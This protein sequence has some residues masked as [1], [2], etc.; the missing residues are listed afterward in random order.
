MV[1]DVR[2]QFDRRQLRAAKRIIG[3]MPVRLAR[4]KGRAIRRT[5]TALRTRV[6][7]AI[8]EDLP[9]KQSDLFKRGSKRRPVIE[10]LKRG[11][12]M[13]RGSPQIIE[14]RIEVTGER[15]PL[16]RFTPRQLKGR[17]VSYKVRK[18][19]GRT[20]IEDGAF[21]VRFSS[22]D[23]LTGET[24][25]RVAVVK[26]RDDGGLSELRGPSVPHAAENRPDIKAIL[27][28]EGEALLLKNMQQQL[29][30]VLSKGRA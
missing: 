17:G 29:D 3:D 13:G 2:V 15:L 9:V 8:A 11:R 20:K 4:V 5:T 7:R 1:A 16:G 6:V 10:S 22:A 21:L 18:Q 26:R 27:K 23:G 25:S 30:F 14:G 28:S 19:G 12:S 24:K